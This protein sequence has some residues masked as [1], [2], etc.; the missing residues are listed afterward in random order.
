MYF[1]QEDPILIVEWFV[2]AICFF[3][4]LVSLWRFYKTVW[5]F[6]RPNYSLHSKLIQSIIPLALLSRALVVT[7]N[8]LEGH[9]P[10]ARVFNQTDPY[11]VILGGFPGYLYFAVYAILTLSFVERYRLWNLGTGLSRTLLGF[12]LLFVFA[13]F[14]T[15]GLLAIVSNEAFTGVGHTIETAFVLFLHLLLTVTYGAVGLLSIYWSVNTAQTKIRQKRTHNFAALFSTLA[16]LVFAS[17]ATCIGVNAFYNEDG[18]WRIAL[19]WVYILFYE[20][21]LAMAITVLNAFSLPRTM[22]AAT[23]MHPTPPISGRDNFSSFSD[24]PYLSSSWTSGSS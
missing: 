19:H 17:K 14:I 5:Y 1:V 12:I 24:E 4:F 21:C 15:F 11:Q 9:N 22:G 3:F 20:V 16:A 13:S 8:L 6:E 7:L 10:A 23:N 18:H 2:A